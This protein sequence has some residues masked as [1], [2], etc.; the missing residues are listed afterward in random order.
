[1][2]KPTLK[3]ILIKMNQ[4]IGN[5]A[6]TAGVYNQRIDNEIADIRYL[7]NEVFKESNESEKNN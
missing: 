7:I 2:D 3:D 5:I 4:H 6:Y 1:M